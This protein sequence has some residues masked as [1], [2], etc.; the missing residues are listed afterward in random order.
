[1]PRHRY[2]VVYELLGC[3]QRGWELVLAVRLDG[4]CWVIVDD[5]L[6]EHEGAVCNEDD[7]MEAAVNLA[8]ALERTG[9]T[10]REMTGRAGVN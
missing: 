3:T 2:G 9:A 6:T 1:M 4:A 5:G 8:I 10:A 7:A